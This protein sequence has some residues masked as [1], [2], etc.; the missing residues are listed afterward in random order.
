MWRASRSSLQALTQ[1]HVR[2]QQIAR[3]NAMMA[4]TAL[5]ERR[6]EHIE[7]EEFLR[8]YQQLRSRRSELH[9]T[10]KIS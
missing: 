6:R 4:S 9:E 2:S 7:A 3:R 5:A 10:A 8:S 1:W